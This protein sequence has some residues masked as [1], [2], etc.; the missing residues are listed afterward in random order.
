MKTLPKDPLN[1]IMAGVGG[2]GNVMAS[3]VLANMLSLKGY[4][5]TIGETFGMS[6]RGGSVMSHL[7]VSETSA[8]SPQIPRGRADVL[9]ALEPIEAVRVMR[10]YGN[11]GVKVLVNTRAIH[12]VGVIAG[13]S[14]YPPLE[15]IEKGLK[16]LTPYVWMLDATEE[17]TKLGNPILSNIIMIGAVSGLNLLP[18]GMAEFKSVIRDFFP[19]K[20]LEINRRAFE[21]GK[22]KVTSA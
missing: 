10:A 5:V 17:A 12:P 8:W 21:V 15:S 13:D 14:E 2:Q 7:R 18:V 6:Q 11:S 22:E 16:E 3:R 20:L 1:I 19:E 4:K 9:I